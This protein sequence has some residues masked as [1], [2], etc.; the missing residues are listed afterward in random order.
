[1]SQDSI[2]NLSHVSLL[3]GLSEAAIASIEKRSHWRRY[4]RDE[5]ILDHDSESRDVFLIVDGS[6]EVI[7]Y[8]ISG[9]E[10]AFGR[11]ATG[12]YFGELS[13]IDGGRR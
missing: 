2:H 12:G 6:V 11:V 3:E 4:A 9:R 5:Q 1:M 10:V 7:N 8:S 13:G